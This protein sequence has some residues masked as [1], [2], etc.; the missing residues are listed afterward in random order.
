MRNFICVSISFFDSVSSM[1]KRNLA[2]L[3]SSQQD[4]FNE[5][6]FKERFREDGL[7]LD[8]YVALP[9]AFKFSMACVPGK[10]TR[11]VL[12]QLIPHS[13]SR[14]VYTGGFYCDFKR[15]YKSPVSTTGE[16]ALEI[17]AKIASVNG[18]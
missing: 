18:P 14:P 6:T 13:Y 16:I 9:L 10:T 7:V 15:D 12:C 2:I 17:A 8:S 11:G 5:W 1:R 3:C 4:P